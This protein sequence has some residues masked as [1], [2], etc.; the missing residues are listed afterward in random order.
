MAK[1]VFGIVFFAPKS[2][3]FASQFYLPLHSNLNCMKLPIVFHK[4]YD[5]GLFGLENMHPFDSKKYGKVFK[6]L[7]D[8][9]ILKAD[10]W[11]TPA[12]K[13]E[14][15]LL[16]K[17]HTEAYLETLKASRVVA[18]IAE[19]SFLKAFPNFI[20]RGRLLNPMRWA[21]AGTV[22]AAELALDFGWAIN[23]SGGYHHAKSDGSS[24]FCFF[25]DINL[26]ANRFFE[27]RPDAEKIMVLDLDAHQGNG[28][29]DIFKDDPRVD[30]FDVYNGDIYPRDTAAARYIRYN[31]A[32]PNKTKEDKYLDILTKELPK[33][34]AESKPEYLIYNAGS[35]I[36]SKDAL[37]GL[38]VSADGI[39]ARDE[40]VFRECRKHNIP[41]VM[42]LSGGY[43]PDSSQI[44]G[45]SIANLWE[46]GLLVFAN[47]IA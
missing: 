36:Y 26:A 14:D 8:A 30:T 34:I 41:I 43:H 24:G 2:K 18:G 15:E 38:L 40:F 5:I 27:L 25:A 4:R 10:N 44:I 47:S 31:H 35:D 39:V 29:E 12:G 22:L 7:E 6:Y 19:M 11:Y 37:G 28:F 33:A 21:T 46:K 13:A 3:S 42:V 20:L 45:R 1:V 23:L 16:L 9:E 17:V 32:L